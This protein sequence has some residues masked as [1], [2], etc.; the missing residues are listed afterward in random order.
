[1]KKRQMIVA[2]ALASLLTL[3]A[4]QNCSMRSFDSATVGQTIQSSTG[5]RVPSST[6][7]PTPTPFSTPSPSPGGSPAPSP[8]PAPTPGPTPTPSPSPSPSPAPAVS[9]LMNSATQGA[10]QGISGQ[11][12][13]SSTF[14]TKSTYAGAPPYVAAS[15]TISIS[16]S[17]SC[18]SENSLT[19]P[20]KCPTQTTNPTCTRQSYFSVNISVKCDSESDTAT[21]CTNFANNFDQEISLDDPTLGNL[22][23]VSASFSTNICDTGASVNYLGGYYPNTPKGK[24]KIVA[25][26]NINSGTVFTVKLI[27]VELLAGNDTTKAVTLDGTYAAKIV[28]IKACT[29]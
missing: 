20:G 17:S 10:I 15:T 12:A 22:V 27:G 25:T 28:T 18:I 16:A 19:N 7:N 26:P 29:P 21:S 6:P 23:S 9:C 5:Q 1:M 24:F 11:P 14:A 4:F 2:A 13:I 3:I 8:G